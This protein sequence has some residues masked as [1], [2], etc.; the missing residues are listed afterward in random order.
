M[1]LI[2]NNTSN[3]GLVFRIYRKPLILQQ[4]TNFKMGKG[5]K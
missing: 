4:E 5:F 2:A 1:E 3:K